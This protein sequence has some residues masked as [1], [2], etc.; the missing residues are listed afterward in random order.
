[1][2]PGGAPFRRPA[3]RADGARDPKIRNAR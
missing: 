3:A 2:P 1:M